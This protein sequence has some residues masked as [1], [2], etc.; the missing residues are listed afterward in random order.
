MNRIPYRPEVLTDQD[1][2][3]YLHGSGDAAEALARILQPD[4][5]DIRTMLGNLRTR[6]G[7]STGHLAAVLGV[8]RIT[9][10]GRS[11]SA[12]GGGPKVRHPWGMSA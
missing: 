3:T 2:R 1:G 9:C 5:S 6:L 10:E 11:E 7:V 12:A 4:D 8:P